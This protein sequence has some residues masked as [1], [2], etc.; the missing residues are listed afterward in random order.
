MSIMS[1]YRRYSK[2]KRRGNI[3][4]EKLRKLKRFKGSKRYKLISIRE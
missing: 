1:K 3:L 4:K 2:L